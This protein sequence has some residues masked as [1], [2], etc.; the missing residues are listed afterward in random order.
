MADNDPDLEAYRAAV[1]AMRALPE[2]DLRNWRKQAEIHQNFCPHDN[3][4]F[5]PWH[6]AYLRSFELICR[7]LS[8][9]SDFALPYWDWT[10]DRQIPTPFRMSEGNELYHDRPGFQSNDSL[11]DDMVGEAV[12]ERILSA[13]TLQDF[14]S[15]RPSGQ[16]ST[17][18]SWQRRRGDATELEFNPHNGVHGT[19]QGDMASYMSPLDPIFWLHHCNAD[20][21]WS[22][23]SSRHPGVDF[24]D[25]WLQMKFS[26]QFTVAGNTSWE[27]SVADLL[28]PEALNYSYGPIPIIVENRDAALIERISQ[29][30]GLAR[31]IRESAGATLTKV[32]AV[33]G[34]EPILV[35]SKSVGSAADITKPLSVAFN[36]NVAVE[37]LF[38]SVALPQSGSPE[39]LRAPSVNKAFAAIRSVSEPKDSSTRVRVFVNCDYLSPQTPVSDPHYVTSFSFFGGG[40]GHGDEGDL[41]VTVDLTEALAKVRRTG[42][43]TGDQIVVQL[44][45]VGAESPQESLVQPKLIDLG[46]L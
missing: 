8:G 38:R 41:S 31:D 23:W 14:G 1:V 32:P 16:D 28:S 12:I 36:T 7:E 27:P 42:G 15:T 17:D 21:I 30:Q 29:W 35:A 40:H 5:L 19:L 46:V 24:D 10:V 20:R 33:S 39:F 18:S 22:I 9:K 6:R 13:V 43:L 44:M 37:E 11:P 26:G 2:G 45:P 25:L 3:W 4:Y 34:G